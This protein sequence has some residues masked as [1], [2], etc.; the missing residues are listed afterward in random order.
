MSILKF[1]GKCNPAASAAN[2][3]YISRDSA[4]D[5]LTF[6]NLEELDAGDK[7][8]NKENALNYAEERE[9]EEESRIIG[10]ERGT[11]RNHNRMIISFDRKEET[12][13][14]KEETHKFL[15]KE[16]P[17]QKA[18]VAIHQDSEHTHAHVWLDC[19]D[20][21]TDK[22]TQ[23]EPSKFKTMDER[24][25]KQYDERYKT[26]Y[27]KEYKEKKAETRAW[28][29][30]QAKLKKEGKQP[31]PED[32][33]ERHNDDKKQI[34]KEKELKDHGIIKETTRENQRITT[35]GH[36]AVKDS[37]QQI[38]RTKQELERSDSAE[39][40]AIH[41]AKELRESIERRSL[42]KERNQTR[43]R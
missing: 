28:K 36:R 9:I 5:S 15:D 31:K 6:H 30:E 3:E 38:N 29:R 16:F 26:N 1:S 8:Q 4:C 12:E 43:G 22:K 41:E 23:I 24:W 11:P 33:P 13:I 35:T 42:E 19:R 34:L 20:K 7:Q 10:N 37:E 17:S 21:D 27:E 2:V 14:A 32:K 25:A 18:I 39:N 40:R